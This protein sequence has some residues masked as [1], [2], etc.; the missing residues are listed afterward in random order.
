MDVIATKITFSFSVHATEVLQK[1][2]DALANLTKGVNHEHATVNKSPLEGGYGNPIKFV[3][4][5]FAKPNS[6]EKIINFLS[7]R[8]SEKEKEHLGLEFENRFD[9]KK[10]NF[11]LRFEKNAL[12]EDKL[13]LT[14]SANIIKLTI[15]LRAFT[16]QI[17]F[18]DFLREKG[19]I[20]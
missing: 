20:K 14:D 2:M 5:S 10:K 11:H 16:K 15:R 6:I 8:L 17:S 1:N 4:V 3:E 13:I 9:F 12:L 19:I 18:K 7:S